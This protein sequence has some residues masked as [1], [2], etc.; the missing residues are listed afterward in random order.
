MTFPARFLLVAAMNPCPCGHLGLAKRTCSCTP[1]EVRA[2]RQRVSGPFLDRIDLFIE[3]GGVGPEDLLGSSTASPASTA[4]LLEAVRAARTLQA[5]RWG[6]ALRNGR[7]HM[8]RMLKE[9]NVKK[10]ALERLRAT[11]ERIGLSARGFV[12]SL[13]V[14]RTVADLDG[15]KAVEEEHVIEALHYREHCD[16]V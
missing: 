13:R 4:A 16:P 7:V 8:A 1:S 9:G 2:Y 15:E 6:D 10:A 5:A 11:T 12:R 14:A 3:L